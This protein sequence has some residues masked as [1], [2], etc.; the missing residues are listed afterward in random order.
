LRFLKPYLWFTIGSLVVLLVFSGTM[1]VLPRLTQY[2][3]DQGIA[4]SDLPRVIRL[5]FGHDRTGGGS[6][7]PPFRSGHAGCS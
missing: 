6:S 2:V 5:T 3:I 4:Q 1:L 7:V